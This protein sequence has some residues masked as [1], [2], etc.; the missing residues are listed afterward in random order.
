MPD[1]ISTQGVWVCVPVR[2]APRRWTGVFIAASQCRCLLSDRR[3]RSHPAC[4]FGLEHMDQAAL[5]SVGPRR[6]SA[7]ASTR[8]GNAT[9]R[10]AEASG[11]QEARR[12][13]RKPQKMGC[14]INLMR[15]HTSAQSKR[16]VNGENKDYFYDF[17]SR[18]PKAAVTAEFILF[19]VPI[20]CWIMLK[21][22]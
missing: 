20:Y 22:W 5:C 18:S 15:W 6:E 11:W 4:G 16:L 7:R 17:S 1:M 8:R 9:G 19:H 13:K 3:S 21:I 10:E 2:S 14:S 12:K